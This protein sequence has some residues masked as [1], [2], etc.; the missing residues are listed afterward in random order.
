VRFRFLAAIL[1][2]CL[3]AACG[4]G[5]SDTAA[6]AV[7]EGGIP[8]ALPATVEGEVYFDLGESELEVSDLNASMTTDIGFDIDAGDDEDDDGGYSMVM[9]RVAGDQLKAT[10]A[11]GEGERV[12]VTISARTQEDGIDYYL[13]SALEKI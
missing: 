3:L 7:D 11:T 12:R 2:T 6:V 5:S 9:L 10:G 4:S 13:V 8:V 1:S